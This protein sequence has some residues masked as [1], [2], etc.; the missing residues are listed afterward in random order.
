MNS[1][2]DIQ[3]SKGWYLK[4]SFFDTAD[5]IVPLDVMATIKIPILIIHGDADQIIPIKDSKK[6]YELIK[7]TNKKSVLCVVKGGDHTFSD[8]KNTKKVIRKTIEW[9]SSLIAN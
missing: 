9:L 5:Q 8:R 2:E 6:G 1:G 7:D 3:I 4:K